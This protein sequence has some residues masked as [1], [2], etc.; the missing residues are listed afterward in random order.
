MA[1]LYDEVALLTSE[2]LD[3]T[4]VADGGD[5]LPLSYSPAGT[6]GPLEEHPAIDGIAWSDVCDFTLTE[7]A[8]FV[9]F[10]RSGVVHHTE[11]LPNPVGPGPVP[12]VNGI[13]PSAL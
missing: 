6:D 4:N 3:G 13:G 12:Y 11:P 10:L 2:A 1:T 8:T 9:G 5:P 7:A